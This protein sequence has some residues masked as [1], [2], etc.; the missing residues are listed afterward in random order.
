MRCC[1]GF[2]RPRLLFLL[3]MAGCIVSAMI[4]VARV[5]VRDDAKLLEPANAEPAAKPATVAEA[6]QVLDLMTFPTMKESDEFVNRQLNWLSYG[7]KPDFK[8][9]SI[10]EFQRKAFTD[11]KWTEL[12]GSH[13]GDE[14]A[15]CRFTREGFFASVTVRRGKGFHWGV[16]ITLHGNVDIRKLPLPSH[17]KPAKFHQIQPSWMIYFTDVSVEKTA[18]ECRKRFIG[19]G[20]QPYGGIDTDPTIYNLL[21]FKQNSLL[22]EV[23]ASR[24]WAK[25]YA[26]KTR[27]EIVTRLLPV[28]LPVPAETMRL[29]YFGKQPGPQFPNLCF[30]TKAS[31]DEIVAFYRQSLE[32]TGWTASADSTVKIGN[33]DQLIFRN[34]AND[35]LTLEMS[36]I[37]EDQVL[38]VTLTH[39]T[40]EEIAANEKRREEERV[41]R[42]GR[43]RA[44]RLPCTA[45]S[46]GSA[47]HCLS[48]MSRTVRVLKSIS[49]RCGLSKS[50]PRRHSLPGPTRISI[51]ASIPSQR[52]RAT[53]DG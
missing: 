33:K 17:F 38:R 23:T 50:V 9:K 16:S 53:K 44:K 47:S 14:Y 6:V 48:G 8:F 49:R 20:W 40:S 30:E 7:L 27:V 5:S 34:L 31:Q 52:D 26:G 24:E 36:F 25:D 15:D 4:V 29:R 41:A 45:A 19:L 12:P 32:S 42:E 21:D 10:L 39:Q 37:E 1:I 28:E 2:R 35:S 11:R 22:L 51:S 46:Q 43:C 18:E 13:L 3:L